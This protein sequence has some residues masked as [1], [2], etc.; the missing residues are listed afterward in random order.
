[1][2]RDL[3]A[4]RKPLVLRDEIYALWAAIAGLIIGLQLMTNDWLLY[5]LF[6]GII[7]FRYIS[8]SRKW[9]LPRKKL[10]IEK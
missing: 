1:M 4:G 2:I 10:Y 8:Y 5:V 3:L 7:F 6:A 9:Q